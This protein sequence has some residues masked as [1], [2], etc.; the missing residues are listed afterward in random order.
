MKLVR[1]FRTSIRLLF[2]VHAEGSVTLLIHRKLELALIDSK[3]ISKYPL[4]A[5]CV[6]HRME[7]L[8]IGDQQGCWRLK[9]LFKPKL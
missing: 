8:L 6:D 1:T 3:V 5:S 7:N 2:A 9:V 4:H